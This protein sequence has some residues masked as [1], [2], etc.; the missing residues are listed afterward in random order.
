MRSSL[1]LT[2][3]AA[4]I[5]GGYLFYDLHGE[6]ADASEAAHVE[7]SSAPKVTV[8][9]ASRGSLEQ[10]FSAYGNLTAV[11]SADIAAQIDGRIA[12]IKV[13]DGDAV[14]KGQVLFTLDDAVAVADLEA[15]Q[16]RFKAA[17]ADFER[18]SKLVKH[19][20]SPA[21]K[22]ENA[23]V[24]LAVAR[25]ELALKQA[26]KRRYTILAPFDGQIGRI[27]LSE[28]ALI[29]AGKTAMQIYDQERLRL[30]FRVP[31][32]LWSSVK[33]GQSFEIRSDGK[34]KLRASGSVSFVAPSADP[35][36]RSLMLTGTI[37]NK[38]R[39]F[40]PGLFVH[41]RLDLGKKNGVVMV[42]Q[43]ALVEKLSGSYVFV[44]ES[45]KSHQR[46][47]EPGVRQD[48]F[49]EITK[50]VKAGAK[51]VTQGQK[52]IRDNM[53]VRVETASSKG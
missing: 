41:I 5:V 12:A 4:I 47:V 44:V 16:A 14:K 3:L 24:K 15:A 30:E 38:H 48:A 32:R 13:A 53:A 42:P 51:V 1:S 23:Q 20:T 25:T 17:K 35:K 52:L 27:R 22:L 46:K 39:H 19:G 34:P 8:A 9:E 6:G 45:G 40:A 7:Q 11:K 29:V 28:G 2:L 36:S 37:A 21:L 10:S 50:G 31:E 43:S 18:V 26:E 33:K 49:V